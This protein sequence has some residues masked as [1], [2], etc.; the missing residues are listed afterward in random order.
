MPNG[1]K[2]SC[3]TQPA[4]AKISLNISNISRRVIPCL[5]GGFFLLGSLLPGSALAVM[6]TPALDW[7]EVLFVENGRSAVV[8]PSF[9]ITPEGQFNADAERAA[10]LAALDG[11]HGRDFACAFPYRYEW[12]RATHRDRPVP[13]FDLAD[14]TELA[15]FRQ[16]FRRGKIRIVYA[17]EQVDTPASAFGHVFLILGDDET[18][19]PLWDSVQFLA[20]TSGT[21]GFLGYAIRGLNGGFLGRYQRSA[22]FQTVFQYNHREQRDLHVADI[23]ATPEQFESLLL[24][25]FEMRKVLLPYYFTSQNCSSRLADLLVAAGLYPKERPKRFP[26]DVFSHYQPA[27]GAGL[28]RLPSLHTRILELQDRQTGAEQEEFSE[29]LG[30]RRAAS[31]L[32]HPRVAELA[33]LRGDYL[34]R[35]LRQAPDDYQETRQIRYSPSPLAPPASPPVDEAFRRVSAGVTRSTHENLLEL[36]FRAGFKDF[37]DATRVGD[38]RSSLVLGDIRL[39]TQASSGAT[40]V[41]Q[42]T[43]FSAMNL[44]PLSAL[45]RRFSWKTSLGYG[46]GL[47][48]GRGKAHGEVG[49][50]L[51][52]E[53]RQLIGGF[54]MDAGVAAG[55]GGYSGVSSVVAWRPDNSALVGLEY[56]QHALGGESRAGWALRMAKVVQ[57]HELKLELSDGHG[58]R[59]WR[60]SYGRAFR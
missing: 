55:A 38:G 59:A 30:G 24:R 18:P 9:F 46:S 47:W 8:S 20:E 28:A 60:L 17:T 33:V 22:F 27:V 51:A 50:G 4:V 52:L 11:A 19:L 1:R 41:G 6:A 14:C 5:S 32:E 54:F 35:R 2:A 3:S 29:Y 13:A 57:H 53:H 42:A 26:S 7:Q 44:Q 58:A 43:L 36:G 21:D 56:R 25:L 10:S 34:F 40:R 23:P 48:D 49:L 39:Q 16:S 12:L 45:S 37:W 31:A 15:T